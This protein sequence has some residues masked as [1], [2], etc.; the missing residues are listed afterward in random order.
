MKTIN[1]P[2]KS[3]FKLPEVCTLTGVKPY[4]LRFWESEFRE[5][6]P[7]TSSSGQKVYSPDDIYLIS[8]IKTLL[9][10]EKCTIDQ[11]K[12]KVKLYLVKES[13]DAKVEKDEDEILPELPGDDRNNKILAAKAKLE[14]IV[15]FTQELQ[16]RHHWH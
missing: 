7:M 15:R 4:V 14:E 6:S 9:F 1:L 3:H 5:I 8:Y 12:E 11:A 13:N 16:N 10:E 2:E